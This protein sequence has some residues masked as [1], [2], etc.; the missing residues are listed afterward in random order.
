MPERPNRESHRLIDHDYTE[1]RSYFVTICVQNGVNAFGDV[2]DGEMRQSTLGVLVERELLLVP[3]R[4]APWILLAAHVVMPNHVHA[5]ITNVRGDRLVHRK[6]RG[7]KGANEAREIDRQFPPE[8]LAPEFRPIRA[9]GATLASPSNDVQ[10]PGDASVAPTL[11]ALSLGAVI[12]GFKSGVTREARTLGLWGSDALWQRDYHDH[13]I[14]NPKAFAR[15]RRYINE[16]PAQWQQ[17]RENPGRAGTD[18]FDQWLE[19]EG[20]Q[21]IP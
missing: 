16:N 5:I 19:E 1:P 14:R 15:I 18:E 20:K 10:T 7:G 2:I 4:R 3:V 13:V 11:E 9:V 21:P 8:P 6:V 12:G 17:D